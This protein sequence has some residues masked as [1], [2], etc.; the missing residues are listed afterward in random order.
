MGTAL[1]LESLTGVEEVSGGGDSTHFLPVKH[2]HKMGKMKIV[3]DVYLTMTHRFIN[4]A[5][6]HQ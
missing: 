6:Y 1:P 2:A 5:K 4:I 3:G